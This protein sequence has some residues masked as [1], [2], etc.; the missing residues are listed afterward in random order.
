[1]TQLTDLRIRKAKLK[2]K[3]YYPLKLRDRLWIG[4]DCFAEN[5]RLPP[6]FFVSKG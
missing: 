6:G 4:I 2:N 3:P 1:M 5:A